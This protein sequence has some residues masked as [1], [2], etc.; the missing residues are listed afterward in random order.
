MPFAN[1]HEAASTLLAGKT[2]KD[3]ADLAYVT[4]DRA[5]HGED[6]KRITLVMR[7]H[8]CGISPREVP[9][10]IFRVGSKHKDGY[11]WFRGPSASAV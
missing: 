3:Q 10:G 4:I 6:K 9:Q 8:G 11:E 1:P 5:A 2:K 7:D